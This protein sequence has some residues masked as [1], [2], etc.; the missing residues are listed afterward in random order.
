MNLK[1]LIRPD[2][3]RILSPPFAWIDRRFL[4]DGFL[5]ALSP[6]ENLLYFFLVLVADRDGVSF[7]SY[8]K[9]CTLLKLDVDTYVQA[10]DGLL[11]KQLIAF[12][13]QGFQVLALPQSG[14]AAP[15][16]SRSCTA[17]VHQEAQALREIFSRLAQESAPG[18]STS[19]QP[20]APRARA[21]IVRRS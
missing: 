10:R 6:P 2:R 3:K 14:V 4:F 15:A 7:Y 19:G 9:I 11:Q 5:A 18:S 12:D 13:G 8:D 21:E 20:P 17:S 16:A 1:T